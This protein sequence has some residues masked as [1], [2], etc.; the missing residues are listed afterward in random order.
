[1]NLAL[2][3]VACLLA[4]LFLIAGTNKL[5]IPKDK[6]AKAPGGGWVDDFSAN[7]L[8][9]LGVVEILAAIGL[10]LPALLDITPV[11][12]PIAA[13]GLT[14]IMTGAVIIRIRRRE[15]KMMLLNVFYLALAAFVALGRFGP[16]SFG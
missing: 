16:E 4:A 5:I 9:T 15:T 12:V 11:L 6:L 13:V 14:T 10:I 7:F 2:W 1:M 8:R 3:I